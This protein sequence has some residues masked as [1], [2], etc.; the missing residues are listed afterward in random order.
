M[1]PRSPQTLSRTFA[2]SDNG[3]N[4]NNATNGE[5]GDATNGGNGDN[6][7]VI[8]LSGVAQPRAPSGDVTR[9]AAPSGDRSPL[10]LRFERFAL[11]ARAFGARKWS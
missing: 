3:D 5:D 8:D 11:E 1:T 6:G 4:G 9:D 10:S 2:D 7:K